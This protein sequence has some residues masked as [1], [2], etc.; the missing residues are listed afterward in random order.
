MSLNQSETTTAMINLDKYSPEEQLTDINLYFKEISD[1]I[2][3]DFIVF[4]FTINKLSVFFQKIKEINPQCKIIF[5]V[6]YNFYELPENNYLKK[7]FT[8]EAINNIEEN[9]WSSDICRVTQQGFHHYLT[10]KLQALAVTKYKGIHS[11]VVLDIQPILINPEIVLENVDYNPQEPKT[12]IKKEPVKSKGSSK[13]Q[14][15]GVKEAHK[16]NNKTDKK[17]TQNNEKKE[18]IKE[19]IANTKKVIV[20]FE[21]EKWVL[22]K[23]KN[24]APFSSY[25]NK[26]D[27]VSEG[28]KEHK[29]GNDLI[30]Y[31]KEGKIHFQ[32]KVRADAKK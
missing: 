7:H 19:T 23:S 11:D 20:F 30:V 13:E 3:A 15:V 10:N 17:A 27:A 21:N 26:K 4:P 28:M 24:S 18:K 2:W 12:T 9:I 25:D 5:W 22:K 31:T 16:P 32:E 8:E 1:L 6:D 29:K 14:S